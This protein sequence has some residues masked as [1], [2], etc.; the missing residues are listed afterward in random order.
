M[1]EI[2]EPTFV[3]WNAKNSHATK[4]SP[5]LIHGTII[6]QTNFVPPGRDF[7]DMG[8]DIRLNYFPYYTVNIK[9]SLKNYHWCPLKTFPMFLD[10]LLF[11]WRKT[12][13]QDTT[14]ITL[15]NLNQM[16]SRFLR[17][18]I[19]LLHNMKFNLDFSRWA[20]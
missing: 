12:S 18:Y 19:L 7:I 9:T 16:Y 10:L 14:G 8:S 17:W 1:P 20:W 13:R 15:S 2:Q 5:Y 4:H 11:Y 3:Y 6:Y